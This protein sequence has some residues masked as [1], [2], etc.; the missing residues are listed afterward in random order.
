[1][2][3]AQIQF[4]PWDRSYYFNANGLE[5]KVGDHVIVETDLGMEMG[6]IL[7]LANIEEKDLGKLFSGKK[8]ED[9]PVESEISSPELK[10]VLRKAL[11][12][13]LEKLPD[14]RQKRKAIEDC[15]RLIDRFE[16]PMKLVDVHFSFD[17]SRLTFSFISEGR[18]D[19]RDLVKEL[20]RHFS[21]GIRLQQIGIRDEAKLMGDYGHC[22]RQL[23]CR[24]F[25]K[26]LSSITSEM[27]EVQ[28]CNH[29]GSDRLSGICGRLMCCLAYE[30]KGYKDMAQTM[31]P[32]GAKVNVD[33]K[34]GVVVGH[35]ILKQSVDVEFEA[36]KG[37]GKV[38]VEVDLNRNKK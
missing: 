22:G 34:R 2:R 33:G 3:V 27:A 17:D 21:R 18:V 16:L 8:T 26:D 5:L 11:P 31:P 13:D 25:L 9:A 24:K 7:S 37:E 14:F 36:E 19:F 6:K 15:K 28:Q 20:T 35:H 4:V 30:E 29:R 23:C 10:P 12:Q 38:R 32:L 1:M